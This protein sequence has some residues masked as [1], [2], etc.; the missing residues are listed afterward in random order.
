MER[1]ENDDSYNIIDSSLFSNDIA[2]ANFLDKIMDI[3][4]FIQKIKTEININNLSNIEQKKG[5]IRFLLINNFRILYKQCTRGSKNKISDLLL[6]KK[7][8]C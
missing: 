4:Y 6:Q 7:Y 5:L 3:F 8:E 1:F 2:E